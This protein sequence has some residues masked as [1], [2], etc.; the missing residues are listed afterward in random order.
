MA[1]H[2]LG[3]AG[4]GDLH[5][6]GGRGHARGEREP[7]GRRGAAQGAE[8]VRTRPRRGL[9][10]GACRAQHPPAQRAGNPLRRR[11]G[12]QGVEDGRQRGHLVAADRAAL[13]VIHERA[14]LVGLERPEEVRRGVVPAHGS[15]PAGSPSAIRSLLRPRRMRPLTVPAGTP[16]AAAIW[17]WEKPPKYASSMT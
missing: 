12:G 15:T 4:G 9:R 3:R 6:D 10:L 16:S 1:D 11:G 17:A 5:D 8:P 13:E 14:R 7:A 2:A